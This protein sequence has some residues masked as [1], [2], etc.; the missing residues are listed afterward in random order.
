MQLRVRPEEQ[1]RARVFVLFAKLTRFHLVLG[2]GRRRRGRGSIPRLPRQRGAKVPA[3]D[4]VL[5][6]PYWR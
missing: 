1:L 3:D 6:G 5:T 4:T 2:G